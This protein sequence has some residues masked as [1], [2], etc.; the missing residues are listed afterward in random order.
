MSLN[1]NVPPPLS[2]P[3]TPTPTEQPA[4]EPTATPA[5]PTPTQ[6]T[7]PLGQTAPPQ[8]VTVPLDQ[9]QTLLS[10]PA[11][12]A[13]YEQR[14]KTQEDETREKIIA[15]QVK[16]G[17]VENALK[18]VREQSAKDLET[19]R[20][21]KLA[22]QTRARGFA[23]RAELNAALAG[24]PFV[25]E[26]AAKQFADLIGPQFE[27]HPEG[28]GFVVRTATFETPA[29]LA[30]RLKTDP[31][32]LHFFKPS[33]AGGSGAAGADRATPTPGNGQSQNPLDQIAASWK[34]MQA[35]S[36]FSA[37]GLTGRRN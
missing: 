30:A 32:Y 2:A 8:T 11:R 29:Q 6:Q 17:E 26:A 1:P 31:N 35:A 16:R 37:I 28:D 22:E 12:L 9:L 13:E 36:P 18:T 5:T 21:L 23:K 33:T 27:A 3:S 15:E 20:G 25:S 19:E 34:A 14:W 4:T 7:L 10:L 24:L